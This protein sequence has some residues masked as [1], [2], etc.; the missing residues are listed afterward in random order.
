MNRTNWQQAIILFQL[1]VILLISMAG[2]LTFGTVSLPVGDIISAIYDSLRSG[3]P[4]D[5]PGQGPLHDIVWLLRMPRILM[6]ACIGAGLATC[7]V[8]M[9]AGGDE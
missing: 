6:A 7:G 5:A 4:I 9:I 8:I 1:C 3:I 2:A